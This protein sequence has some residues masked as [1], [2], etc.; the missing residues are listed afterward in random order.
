MKLEWK[1][2]S[3]TGS[4]LRQTID[5][6]YYAYQIKRGE[7]RAGRVMFNLDTDFRLTFSSFAVAKAYCERYESDKVIVVGVV[8]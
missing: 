4:Q 6:Q 1:S 3:V 7:W 2:A 8:A 5:E